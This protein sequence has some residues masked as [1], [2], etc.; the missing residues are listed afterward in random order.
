MLITNVKI[1]KDW[2]NKS[3]NIVFKVVSPYC[4]YDEC[5]LSHMTTKMTKQTNLDAYYK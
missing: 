5:F 2:S 3:R 4:F 1:T